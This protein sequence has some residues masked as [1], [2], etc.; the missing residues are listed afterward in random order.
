MDS[1]Y[2][3]LTKAIKE[4]PAAKAIAERLPS[5][6]RKLRLPKKAANI[7]KEQPFAAYYSLRLS[8]KHN[9]HLDRTQAL[10]YHTLFLESPVILL[11]DYALFDAWVETLGW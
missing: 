1:K 11:D 2:A 5:S 10:I 4:L 3:A 6:I 9:I 8:Q 7:T